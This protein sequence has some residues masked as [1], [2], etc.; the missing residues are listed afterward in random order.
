MAV[1][2]VVVAEMFYLSTA[3][4]PGPG[5]Q[6]PGTHRNRMVLWAL[7]A[8][9]PLQWAF[10][11]T[12]LMQEIFGSADLSVLEWAKVLGAGLLVFI[13]AELEKFVI[14]RS[15]MAGRLVHA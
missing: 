6:P 1:N 7:A 15:P 13:V 12:P 4:H 9:I 11:H 2:A 14:R 5:A 3:A 10:T 8:C